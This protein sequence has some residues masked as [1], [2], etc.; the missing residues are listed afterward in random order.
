MRRFLRWSDAAARALGELGFE[1]EDFGEGG[2]GLV[3]ASVE[4]DEEPAHLGFPAGGDG[5]CR[6][7]RLRG[8]VVVGLV[9]A[10]E[11]AAVAE[12][13]RV[14][15]AAGGGDLGEHLGPHRGV[16]LDVLVEQLGR[17]LQLEAD[18]RRGGARHRAPSA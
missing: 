17:D 12:E 15:A 5:G 13:E 2:G 8:L 7:I 6:E 4:A 1:V 11:P 14:V 10:D 16:A 18:A 3:G 9:V